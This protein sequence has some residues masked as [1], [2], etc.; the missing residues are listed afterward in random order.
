[1]RILH[2]TPDYHPTVGGGELYVKE[3]SER[4]AQRGHDVSVLTLNSRGVGLRS[5]ALPPESETINRVRV[6]RL[7]HT[8]AAHHRFLRI[9]GVHRLL[10]LFLGR[11]RAGMLTISPISL[12]G[13]LLTMRAHADVVAVFNWYHTSLAYQTRI[14]RDFQEFSFVGVPLC[15]TE[16][17]WAQ[18]AILSRTLAR[19]DAV[20]T[21]TEY[22]KHFV[23]ARSGQRNV[24]VVGAGVDPSLFAHA[25]GG[26]I[27]ARYHIGDAPVVGYV[28]RMSSTKGVLTLI[29]A[30]KIVWKDNP[31]ARLLLAGSGLPT[32]PRCDPDMR[33]A[34]E[35]LTADEKARIVT[36]STFTDEEKASIFDALDL[37]VMPSLAESFGIAYLE[38]WMCRKAVVG[39]R[40]GSTQCVIEDGVDGVLVDPLDHVQ[41]GRS[42]L[43]LLADPQYRSRLGRAGHAKSLDR[44]TWDKVVD[45]VERVYAEARVIVPH[46][47]PRA[48]QVVA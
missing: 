39:S 42:L 7:N 14:A 41:L 32:S 13:W 17:P 33:S 9:R 3:V 40:I 26:A 19:C 25:N 11:E 48:K 27:R 8:Y 34:F 43:A 38:A 5:G 6:R 29:A 20:A 28:G 1:M 24:H 31:S 23:E 47:G 15:H 4:L 2:I 37:F 36:I 45:R 21:M 30:M 10:G 44:F 46:D 12:Q 18:A 16:R 35:G 22:E